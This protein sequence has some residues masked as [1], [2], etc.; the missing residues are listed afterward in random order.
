MGASH[1]SHCVS[2]KTTHPP[3]RCNEWLIWGFI[4]PA[5]Y[6]NL[7]Q[8]RGSSQQQSSEDGQLRPPLSLPCGSAAPSVQ[9]CLLPY[10]CVSWRHF[11][12]NLPGVLC[13]SICFPGIQSKTQVNWREP[14]ASIWSLVKIQESFDMK[15]NKAQS[16]GG[17]SDIECIYNLKITCFKL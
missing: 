15:G 12:G 17:N 5:P 7:R 10:K 1:V 6:I 2:P 8:L 4:A 3:S 14:R 11:L 9:S 16:F 13:L